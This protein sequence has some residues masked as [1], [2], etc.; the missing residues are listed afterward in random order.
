MPPSLSEINLSKK[1]HKYNFDPKK[2]N[3]RD[4]LFYDPLLCSK[5]GEV[6]LVLEVKLQKKKLCYKSIWLPLEMCE[7]SKQER[8]RRDTGNVPFLVLVV[9]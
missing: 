8:I 2:P 6:T 9:K 5:P 7:R 3:P 4:N 1:C